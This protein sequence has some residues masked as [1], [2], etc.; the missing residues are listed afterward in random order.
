MKK[1]LFVLLLIC[2]FFTMAQFSTT[3]PDSVCYQTPGSAYDVVPLGAGFIY[4][5]VVS[6]PGVITSGQGT[7]SLGVDW[8]SAAPGLIPNGVSLIATSPS[9]CSDSE[10]IDVFIVNIVPVITPIGPFCEPDPCIVLS[11][12]PAGGVFTGVGVVGGQFCPTIS[13]SGTFNIAYT[14]TIDLGCTFTSTISTTVNPVPVLTPIT[15][16]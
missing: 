6:S 10:L 5:W 4:N 2:P 7:P 3:T 14:Y 11:A 8:S 9:G 16:N 13:G 15:H 12:S 1:L